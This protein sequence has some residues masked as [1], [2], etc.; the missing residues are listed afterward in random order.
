MIIGFVIG[1]FLPEGYRPPADSMT[2]LLMILILLVG[3]GLK[4]SGITLKEVIA[5]QTWYANQC[6]FSPWRVLMG[7]LVLADL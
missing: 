7:M 1:M 4:G 3:I 5:K 2:V 6:Y